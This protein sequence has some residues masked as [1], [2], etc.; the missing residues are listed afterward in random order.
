MNKELSLKLGL[1][2]GVKIEQILKKSPKKY[3]Y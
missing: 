2:L 3:G 1:L